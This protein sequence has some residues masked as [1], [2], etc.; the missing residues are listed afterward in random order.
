MYRIISIVM[1]ILIF[2]GCN[3]IARDDI[4]ENSDISVQSTEDNDS[5][6]MDDIIERDLT[7]LVHNN[8]YIYDDSLLVTYMDIVTSKVSF[9]KRY[10]VYVKR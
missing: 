5:M 9:Y 8:D 10:G 7:H 4:Y 1:V 6:E 3:K 2:T